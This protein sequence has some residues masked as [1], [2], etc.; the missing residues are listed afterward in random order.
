[1]SSNS[2]GPRRRAAARP[3]RPTRA[4]SRS[5]PG[6]GRQRQTSDTTRKLIDAAQLALGAC[7]SLTLGGI[8]LGIIL[9]VV[10]FVM[11]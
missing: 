3:V 8:L 5:G 9:V 6:P 10:I 4:D 1:M 11:K 7:L 2:P